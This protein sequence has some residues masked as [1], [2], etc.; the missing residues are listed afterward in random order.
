MHCFAFEVQQSKN[1]LHPKHTYSLELQWPFGYGEP[2]FI[3]GPSVK[4]DILNVSAETGLDDD[5]IGSLDK[6][7]LHQAYHLTTQLYE[8]KDS[9]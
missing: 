9:L 7:S 2:D 6:A 1:K 5:D 8:P 4:S 3:R